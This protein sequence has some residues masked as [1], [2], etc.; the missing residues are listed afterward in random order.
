VKPPAITIRVKRGDPCVAVVVKGPQATASC[1]MG[2]VQAAVKCAA[3]SLRCSESL[4]LI[5]H[6]EDAAGFSF[7][8]AGVRP[9]PD[10]FSTKGGA[11]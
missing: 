5:E 2:A 10:L 6:V 9:E 7:Y 4:A 11:S 1:T 3:K 8:K